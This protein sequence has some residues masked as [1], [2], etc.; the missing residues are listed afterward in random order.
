MLGQV[1]SFI[2]IG[3]NDG[4]T[5]SN[6]F[7]F[8]ELGAA[9]LCFEPGRDVYALLQR[10]HKKNSAV[11]CIN[12]AIAKT[13]RTVVLYED[14][15]AGLLSSLHPSGKNQTLVKTRSVTARPL[16]YWLDRYERF[17]SVD[18]LSIDVEGGER[19]VPESID[20]GR[21]SAKII[22]AEIDLFHPV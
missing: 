19:S 9:G 13:Q 1:R 22:I 7:Y 5:F 2:D 18:L 21:F 10:V 16:S 4:I 3:A 15:Y 12:E 17:R 8:A 11:L 20:F 14:G 6:T